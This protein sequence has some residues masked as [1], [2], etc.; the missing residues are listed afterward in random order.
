MRQNLQEAGPLKVLI[1]QYGGIQKN[2]YQGEL[3]NPPDEPLGS[4]D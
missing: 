2:I 1:N 3:L 4:L